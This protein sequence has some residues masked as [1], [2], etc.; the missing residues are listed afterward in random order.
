MQGWM[1]ALSVA[2]AGGLGSLGRYG[3]GLVLANTP[4]AGSLGWATLLVNL[5]GA[6]AIGVGASALPAAGSPCGWLRPVLLTGLLGGWTTFAAMGLDTVEL[7]QRWGL[8][9]ALGWV[10]V[11][12]VLGLAGVMLGLWLG[13]LL[14]NALHQV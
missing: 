2:V 3:V 9:P 11:Q 1:L 8:W 6:V 10:S 7:G 14:M 4:W 12:V 5:T 13:Q